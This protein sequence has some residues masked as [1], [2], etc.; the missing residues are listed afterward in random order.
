MYPRF[1]QLIIRAQVGNLSSHTTKYSSPALTQKAADDTINI[2]A[3]DVIVDDVTNVVAHVAP[4][5]PPSLI[6]PPSSP[7]QQ[8]QLLQPTTISMDLLHTLLETCTALTR[9]VNNL[10]QDKIAQALEIIKLKKWVRKLEKKR[11]LTV[12]GLKRLRKV[13]TTQ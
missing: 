4:T 10:E 2:V 9:R 12:S 5:P 1:L 3:D 6:A 13:R 7:P 8:Q 11:K